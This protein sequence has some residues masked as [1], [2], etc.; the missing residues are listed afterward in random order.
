MVNK[1]VEMVKRG[2]VINEQ[3]FNQLREEYGLPE[4]SGL[5]N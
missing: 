3:L 2:V 1:I 5:P 4:I